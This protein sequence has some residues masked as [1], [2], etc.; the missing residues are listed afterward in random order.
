MKRLNFLVV[1]IMFNLSISGQCLKSGDLI[2][3]VESQNDFSKAISDSTVG[4]DSISF[5]HVGIIEITN[6]DKFFVI[7]ASPKKGVCVTPL[8]EFIDE[9]PKLN[10]LPGVV[11]KRLTIPI[12]SEK[13]IEK[14][15]SYLGKKYD[16]WYLPDNE[17][18]Y[19]SELVYESFLDEAGNH[20]FKA[21][22]MNF[23]AKDGK[24]PEFWVKLFE[25]LGREIP[26]GEL[27][28]NPNDLSKENLL[29]EIF[30]YF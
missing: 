9:A 29:K 6:E 23:R 14:A 2:F 30:C 15:K 16:W 26:E 4:T 1:A 20:I 28:T 18:I 17:Y 3:Q 8:E 19:C 11:I 25:E 12:S 7:E 22:P 24:M 13:I 21:E 27:G 5:V 10:G